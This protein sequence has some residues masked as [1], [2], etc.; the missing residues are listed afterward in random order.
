MRPQAETGVHRCRGLLESEGKKKRQFPASRIKPSKGTQTTQFRPGG[1]VAESER[2]V[3]A[4]LGMLSLHG[5]TQYHFDKNINPLTDPLPSQ[6]NA[7]L[8]FPSLSCKL[9]G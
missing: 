6:T 5:S 2:L 3:V 8:P 9:N 4:L 1:S 7:A